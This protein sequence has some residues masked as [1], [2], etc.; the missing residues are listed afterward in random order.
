[1]HNKK[2]RLLLGYNVENPL[3]KVNYP[4]KYLYS[5]DAAFLHEFFFWVSSV[6][7]RLGVWDMVSLYIHYSM[8]ATY[9]TGWPSVRNVL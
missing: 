2:P 6:L 1:M 8:P 5:C 4:V 9:L 7:L 3:K